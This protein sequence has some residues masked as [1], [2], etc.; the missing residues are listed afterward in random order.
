MRGNHNLNSGFV[1][2]TKLIS[3]TNIDH[4]V[5]QKGSSGDNQAEYGQ[6]KHRQRLSV[7]PLTTTNIHKE[8]LYYPNNTG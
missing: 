6:Y 3:N 2:T 5:Y 4:S 7:Q 1:P 8:K